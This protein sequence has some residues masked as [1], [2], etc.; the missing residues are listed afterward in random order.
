V[1]ATTLAGLRDGG[2]ADYLDLAA[3]IAGARSMPEELSALLD[4]A[5]HF[6]LTQRDATDVLDDVRAA[7]ASWR[8]V[9]AANGV[10]ATELELFSE[11]FDR[12]RR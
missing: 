12:A 7:A 2:P 11:V 5:P 9:A 8:G 3:A 6:G 1:S 4:A 10:G